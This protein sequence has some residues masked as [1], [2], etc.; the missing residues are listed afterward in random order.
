MPNK[1]FSEKILNEVKKVYA[2]YTSSTSFIDHSGEKGRFREIGLGRIISDYLPKN[3]SIGNG[4]VTDYIG[5]QSAQT[6][7]IIYDNTD[8]SPILYESNNGIFPIESCKYCFEIKSKSNSTEIADTI[9]KFRK[10]KSLYSLNGRKPVAVY[11]AYSSD[12]N[13]DL[14]EF[15]RYIKYDDNYK[16]NP[17]IDV[18]CVIGQ[19]YW[20]RTES[21]DSSGQR[22]NYSFDYIRSDGDFNETIYLLAG[23]FNT[24]NPKNS[25]GHYLLP[26]GQFKKSYGNIFALGFDIP[27]DK[28]EYFNEFSSILPQNDFQSEIDLLIKAI[29]DENNFKAYVKAMLQDKHIMTPDRALFYSEYLVK[30]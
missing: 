16:V 22:L 3:F 4:I 1:L 24:L 21:M 29:P 9:R 2:D 6:D 28:I 10:L 25:F 15:Q 8:L 12:L 26:Q 13:S 20:F 18:I 7:L 5:T 14:D 23:V 11:F 30:H 27:N 19:G 17:A